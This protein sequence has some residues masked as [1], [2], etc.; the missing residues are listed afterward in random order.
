M[1]IASETLIT[2]A[3]DHLNT[4][5]LKKKEYQPLQLESVLYILVFIARKR[6]GLSLANNLRISYKPIQL[7]GCEVTERGCAHPF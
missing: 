7:F 2:K 4:I 6:G 3:K 5:Y 1:N